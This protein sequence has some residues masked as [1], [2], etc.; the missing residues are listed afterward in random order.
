M[1]WK[2][3]EKI[4]IG[5]KIIALLKPNTYGDDH[6]FWIDLSAILIDLSLN[7]LETLYLLLLNKK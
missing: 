1:N 3:Q 6:P 4:R 2:E 5:K 7:R